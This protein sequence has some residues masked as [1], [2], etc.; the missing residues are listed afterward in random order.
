MPEGRP[1]GTAGRAQKHEESPNT[2]GSIRT[3]GAL[4]TKGMAPLAS[5]ARA[6]P[7]V[8]VSA[9]VKD[10][11]ADAKASAVRPCALKL[12]PSPTA[13]AT[14]R[15]AVQLAAQPSPPTVLLSSQVSSP[16]LTPSPQV[17]AVAGAAVE[18]TTRASA[19]A[20]IPAELG[21]MHPTLARF[22]LLGKPI[23]S[24]EGSQAAGFIPIDRTGRLPPVCDP[25]GRAH[26]AQANRTG[27]DRDQWVA[28]PTLAGGVLSGR[29]GAEERA[30]LHRQPLLHGRGERD[31]LFAHPSRG[32]RRLAAG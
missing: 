25:L 27:A 4:T 30:E 5:L 17:C 1:S 12:D 16:C 18:R 22:A 11:P 7:M 20:A 32:V 15:S 23:P 14:R 13:N 8:S 26:A 2:T 24:L 9:P 29:V 6:L 31:V 10:R 28:V 19:A 21:V 3:S